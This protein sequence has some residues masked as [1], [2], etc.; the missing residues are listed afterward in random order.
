[1]AEAEPKEQEASAPP[2]AAAKAETKKERTPRLEWAGLLRKSFALDVL[3]CSRCDV[4]SG[5]PLRPRR[6][7]AYRAAMPVNNADLDGDRCSSF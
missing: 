3:V 4:G 7:P 6:Q 5:H 1:M 2:E